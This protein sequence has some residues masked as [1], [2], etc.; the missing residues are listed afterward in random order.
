MQQRIVSWYE[1]ISTR[2]TGAEIVA[3][4][5]SGPIAAL[6]GHIP[7]LAANQWSPWIIG[8]LESIEVKGLGGPTLGQGSQ[9]LGTSGRGLLGER[10]S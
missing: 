9:G 5:H 2:F 6:A 1:E 7:H 10:Q 8:N 3:V 4:S